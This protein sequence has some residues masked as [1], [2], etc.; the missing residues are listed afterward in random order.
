MITFFEKLREDEVKLMYRTPLL[1]SILIAGADNKIDK[2]EIKEVVS[3]TKIKQSK[4]R[5]L[6]LDYYQEIGE[7]FEAD[8]NEE[9]ASLPAAADKRN[10]YI[11]EE[12]RRL[13]IIL[14]KLDR[15]FAIE[16]YESM[17]EIAHTVAHASGGI[18]GY[19]TVGT[20]ESRYMELNFVRNPAKIKKP[21]GK[22]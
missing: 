8:L 9:I 20:E 15:N 18:F 10:N 12:L 13:N 21:Q 16:F 3:L 5:N 1:V 19:L 2:K 4:G 7:T 14:P 6:L 17:K 22:T 11:V